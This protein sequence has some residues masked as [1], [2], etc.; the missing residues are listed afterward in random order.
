M[1]KQDRPLGLQTTVFSLGDS[2][3]LGLLTFHGLF[4]NVSEPFK[5]LRGAS[6]E[7]YLGITLLY[8]K[9][10]QSEVATGQLEQ[11]VFKSPG[12]LLKT[13]VLL[14]TQTEN[15]IPYRFHFCP[16]LISTEFPRS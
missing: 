15:Q 9:L 14:Q 2:R 7:K 4:D 8:S 1:S 16:S 3:V 12:R 6:K 11:P 13:A 5:C 10:E